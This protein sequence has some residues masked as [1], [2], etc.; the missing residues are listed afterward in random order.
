MIDKITD[1]QIVANGVQSLANRPN[2]PSRYGASGLT[3]T[4]LKQAFDNLSSILAEK[5]NEIIDGL[6]ENGGET[7]SITLPGFTNITTLGQFLDF[8]TSPNFSSQV[9]QVYEKMGDETSVKLQK[10][11]FDVDSVLMRLAERVSE[12]EKKEETILSIGDKP[13]SYAEE[14]KMWDIIGERPKAFGKTG[15][16][17]EA[18][19]SM[20]D[21]LEMTQSGVSSDISDIRSS[22]S[23]LDAE[24]EARDKVLDRRVTNLEAVNRGVSYLEESVSSVAYEAPIPTHAAPF[25]HLDRVGGATT[26]VARREN[27]LDLSALQGGII[28]SGGLIGVVDKDTNIITINGYSSGVEGFT[29]NG[30]FGTIGHETEN[31]Y[32]RVEH[33]GGTTTAP[34]GSFFFSNALIMGGISADLPLNGNTETVW[35]VSDGGFFDEES[36]AAYNRIG[37]VNINFGDGF[38]DNYQLRITLSVEEYSLTDN[39]PTALRV[40]SKNLMP[41][42][43]KNGNRYIS[44]TVTFTVDDEG[45]VT[46]ERTGETGQ[47]AWFVFCDGAPISKGKYTMSGCVG[48]VLNSNYCFAIT[49]RNNDGT[50]SNDLAYTDGTKTFTVN[51]DGVMKLQIVIYENFTGKVVF[52]PQLE[53]GETATEYE[54]PS[55]VISTTALPNLDDLIKD[56]W[57]QGVPSVGG[58]YIT[59]TDEGKVMYQKTSYRLVLDGTKYVGTW[60]DNG[61]KSIVL[62]C[63]L[64]GNNLPYAV[65]GG[66]T[67]NIVS[68]DFE[69]FSREGFYYVENPV[70]M[71]SAKERFIRFYDPSWESL[72]DATILATFKTECQ[73]RYAEG[74]PII[75]EYA[76]AELPDPVD[77]T[78]DFNRLF[79]G[80]FDGFIE[81]QGNGSVIIENEHKADLPTTLTYMVSTRGG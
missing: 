49:T 50:V 12:I 75:I 33:I 66:D 51:N 40:M 77:I 39:K 24:L 36:I 32:L 44:G 78:E 37:S 67:I 58:N 48:G 72:D 76:L 8:V 80:E 14:E 25:A 18:V 42:P 43:Y 81:G 54:K 64:M 79:G 7:V 23:A 4:Q 6:Q 19:Y 71:V 2:A 63:N 30:D 21:G 74:N 22:V 52:K 11:I 55:K 41:F 10:Y 29:F 26:R 38:F 46:A 13:S 69:A 61:K 45:V 31:K 9:L 15:S 3:A 68:N 70:R 5:I 20:L 59:F 65:G 16:L 34:F 47:K 27:I 60:A 53:R 56:G 73:A 62:Q 1:G 28:G 35:E 17:W 57:G